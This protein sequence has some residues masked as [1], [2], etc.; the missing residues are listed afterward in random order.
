MDVSRKAL[1]AAL[2][3]IVGLGLSWRALSQSLPAPSLRD[4]PHQARNS[5]PLFEEDHPYFTSSSRIIYDTEPTEET[6]EVV[7][8]RASSRVL[9]VAPDQLSGADSLPPDRLRSLARI[10]ERHLAVVLS[11]SY[12]RWLEF[13]ASLD[14][15]FAGDPGEEGGRPVRAYFEANGTAYR[16]APMSIEAIKIR[17]LYR[18]GR[19]IDY[20]R[21]PT[22]IRAM[23]RGPYVPPANPARSHTDVYEI[24]TLMQMRAADDADE[25]DDMNV[26]FSYFWSEKESRWLPFQVH[27]YTDRSGRVLMYAY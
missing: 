18:D 26:G 6:I 8:E 19:K 24:L 21:P 12:D 13:I 9:E 15:S 14:R 4:T 10:F 25:P 17:P 1:A 11:G 23:I 16:L 2:F 7:S 22:I 5:S 20:Q 27:T 3:M